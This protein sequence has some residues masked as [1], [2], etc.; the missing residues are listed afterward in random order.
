MWDRERG[1]LLPL[2]LLIKAI[3]ICIQIYMRTIKESDT[4]TYE[5]GVLFYGSAKGIG[6]RKLTILGNDSVAGG[7]IT[8]RVSMER[9]AHFAS[10]FG[11]ERPCNVS[12]SR[13]V[14][15]GDLAYKSVY[16]REEIH[17]VWTESRIVLTILASTPL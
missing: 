15:W 2:I 1:L 17:G 6:L 12:V 14:A 4:L 7:S 13:N 8:A 10:V 3:K 16:L 5:F 11:A 9:P